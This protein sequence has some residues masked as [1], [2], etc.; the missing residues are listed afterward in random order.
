M[1]TQAQ[2]TDSIVPAAADRDAWEA[3]VAAVPE[4]SRGGYLVDAAIQAIQRGSVTPMRSVT[5]VQVAPAVVS[6]PH[7]HRIEEVVVPG[8]RLGRHVDLRAATHRVVNGPPPLSP[9]L[10][11]VRHASS[12][13]LPLDQQDTKGCTDRKSVV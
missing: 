10:F 7:V 3:L 9:E 11:S 1:S 6:A 8:R 12:P 5:P 2:P 4:G 13:N